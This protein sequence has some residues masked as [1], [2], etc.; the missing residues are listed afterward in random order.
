MLPFRCFAVALL[1]ATTACTRSTRTAEAPAPTP[2]PI[3][4]GRGVIAAMHARY[5]GKFF[6]T[7]SFSQN[8]TNISQSG[9]EIKGVW[10]EYLAVPGRLRIDYLPLTSRSGVLYAGGRIH[11]FTDNKPQAPQRGWN[12]L[13]VLI[14][15]VYGQ[16]VDTTV[17]QLDSLGFDL[18]MMHS[19]TWQGRPVMV[20]GARPGDTTTSQFWIDRDSLLVRRVIQRDARG[21]RPVVSDIRFYRYQDVGGYPVAFDVHF[22]RDGRLYFKEEYFNVQVNVLLPPEIF[23]PTKWGSSQIR[24]SPR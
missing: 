17:L 20:V 12:P 19:S 14:A 8:T 13:A 11:A 10:N 16:A 9:R 2:A 7:L 15:D 23:D 3:S 1:L 18:A 5:A 4:D 21:A 24:R 6:T 22:Y